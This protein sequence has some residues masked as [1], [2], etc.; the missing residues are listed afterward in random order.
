MIDAGVMF[1]FG[2]D[3]VES[4]DKSETVHSTD[5]LFQQN[6]CHVFIYLYFY[7]VLFLDI[8]PLMEYK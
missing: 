6:Y 5:N 2:E 3:R 7:C 4:G 1:S 8:K